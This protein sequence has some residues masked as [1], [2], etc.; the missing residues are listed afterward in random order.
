MMLIVAFCFFEQKTAYEMRISDWSSDVCS[1]DLIG[2]TAAWLLSDASSFVTG[3]AIAADGGGSVREVLQNRLRSEAFMAGWW[4]S[5]SPRRPAMTRTVGKPAVS[6]VKGLLAQEP[7]ALSEIVRR[8]M[9]EML[10]AERSDERRVGREC[11]ST[12]I[13]GWEREQ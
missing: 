10:E 5:T 4:C 8:V 2:E 11:V 9:Q 12:C 7:D 3:A 1:S 6:A 13:S